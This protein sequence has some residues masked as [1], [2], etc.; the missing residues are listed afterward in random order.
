M[1]RQKKKFDDARRLIVGLEKRIIDEEA[2]RKNLEGKAQNIIMKLDGIMQ[3]MGTRRSTVSAQGI[4]GQ[5]SLLQVNPP[6]AS[7]TGQ[8]KRTPSISTSAQTVN[9]PSMNGME[10][11]NTMSTFSDEN[12]NTMFAE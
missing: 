6:S 3:Q 8:H 7:P 9:V 4:D 10:N 5:P 12:N 2:S 1:T 11:A